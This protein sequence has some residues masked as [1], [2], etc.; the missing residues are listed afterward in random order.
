VSFR[1]DGR[2]GTG[3]VV[4][5]RVVDLTGRR[6]AAVAPDR[7]QMLADRGLRVPPAECSGSF[8]RVQAR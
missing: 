7:V 5:E 1:G 3:A 4:D 6:R 2:I 8:T